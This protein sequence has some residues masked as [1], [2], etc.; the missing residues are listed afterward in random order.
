MH[1]GGGKHCNFN[2]FLKRSLT[3]GAVLGLGAGTGTGTGAGAEADD[4]PEFGGSRSIGNH[5]LD[6]FPFNISLFL[7]L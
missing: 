4:G 7:W 1:F 2:V 6:L 5:H 3:G